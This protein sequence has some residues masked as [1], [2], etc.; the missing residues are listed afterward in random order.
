MRFVGRERELDLLL[1][2]VRR[3]PAV[4]LVEGEAGIGKSR[5][6]AE[7]SAVLAREG[8]PVLAGFCHPLRV[9]PSGEVTPSSS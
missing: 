9:T 3:P 1:S 5:L 2:A 6:I 7:A 8:R 4:V